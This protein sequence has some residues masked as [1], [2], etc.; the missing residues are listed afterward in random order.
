MDAIVG[1]PFRARLTTWLAWTAVL[2]TLVLN[3]AGGGLGS[4]GSKYLPHDL[5]QA[6]GWF[7]LVPLFSQAFVIVGALIVWRRPGNRIGWVAVAIGVS[8]G[9]EEFVLG[10]FSVASF[11]PHRNSLP[12][13]GVANWLVGWVWLIPVS[14][15]IF[16]LPFLFPDG[17]PVSPSW[18]PVAWIDIG[19]VAAEVFGISVSFGPIIIAG[20]LILLSC[21]ILAPVTLVIRYRMS[22]FDKRQQIKWF[23]AAEVLLAI[24]AVSGT[25]VSFTVYHN[26]TVVFNAPFD[27]LIPLALTGLAV[28]IGIAVLRYH[29][30]DIDVF[31][32]RALV[33]SALVVLIS[34]LYLI[35]VVSIGTRMNL[36]QNVDRAVPFVVAAIVALA[37]Q[38]I[39]TRLQRLANRLVYGRR[40]TPYE[41]LANLSRSMAEISPGDELPN[42]MARAL[43]EGTDA[44]R[45][46]VWLHV[47]DELRRAAAWPPVSGRAPTLELNG[48]L[49]TIP[50][51]AESAPVRYQGE[52]L[53]VLAIIKREPI[54]P[55]ESRLVSDLAHEAGLAL[56]NVRLTA[57]LI[58]RLDELAASRRRIV[59]AQDD[60][61]HRLERDLHDGAQQH[62]I[63][64]KLK[65][66]LAKRSGNDDPRQVQALIDS[67]LDE[68]DE[69]I[70][71]LRELARG[72]YPPVLTDS[73][74]IA[75]LQPVARRSPLPTQIEAGSVR[76]Y[77]AEI[78]AAA[79]F[80]CLEALQNVAKHARASQVVIALT[81]QDGQLVF[82]VTD[83][84]RGA[85]L[86]KVRMGAGIQNMV[87]RLA[88]LGGSLDVRSAPDG[89]TTVSGRL[90]I[91]ERS[92][93]RAPA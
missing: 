17:K 87:D 6:T 82:S 19:A 55:I 92:E 60:E 39:R 46:E 5:A 77:A 62:L 64:L 65:L 23:A 50:E 4:A 21:A 73:G 85:D 2:A 59:T 63:A 38:P 42:R 9:L 12:L 72:L 53:G 70:E 81:E 80:V 52:D 61:R 78:E 31:L 57:E 93:A 71:T 32:R 45:A 86:T 89:G 27:V 8:A 25:I 49:P 24:V 43:A 37:F 11:G 83:N 20:Q 90:P 41:V 69:A 7:R 56:K 88:A 74:L 54:T 10:Y 13:V 22:G 51:A 66:G 36:P 16:F 18:R 91:R 15:T 67:L 84:G 34:V 33:Y 75:A 58:Q 26:N 14:L 48:G 35:V 30:Y 1:R 68:T 40:A 76:R 29:L 3:G 47:G 79:Y 44:D 28:S